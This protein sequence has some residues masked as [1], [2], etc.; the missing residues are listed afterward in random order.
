MLFESSIRLDYLFLYCG[1]TTGKK[2]FTFVLCVNQWL[3]V[4]CVC[5]SKVTSSRGNSG[6]SNWWKLWHEPS[7][8]IYTIQTQIH[9]RTRTA[10]VLDCD[11]VDTKRTATTP[12]LLSYYFKYIKTRK[13]FEWT[14]N[15]TTR[16]HIH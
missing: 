13:Y 4:V 2:S 7:H 6:S 16:T 1:S 11:N 9:R 14:R 12:I 3:Y 5:V 8:E 15:K 10:N